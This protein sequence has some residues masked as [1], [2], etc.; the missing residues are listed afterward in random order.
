[1]GPYLTVPTAAGA[2]LSA[3]ARGQSRAGALDR[4]RAGP[5]PRADPGTTT[6]P[7]DG[8]A[9]TCRGAHAPARGP[10]AA[11][12]LFLQAAM[13][14]ILS[15][16]LGFWGPREKRGRKRKNRGEGSHRRPRAAGAPSP[17]PV[18]AGR[19]P[20]RRHR[21]ASLDRGQGGKWLWFHRGSR[22]SGLLY[23]RFARAAV[24][25]ASAAMDGR[26]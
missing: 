14:S 23:H 18:E 21:R 3:H 10:A 20:P 7:L 22:P 9:L 26:D 11:S 15:G 12:P 5:P 4:P 16:P 2:A 6:E 13:G 24:G 8:G 25:S 17:S 19:G 1:V